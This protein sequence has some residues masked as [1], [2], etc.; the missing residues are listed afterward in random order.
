MWYLAGAYGV[1]WLLVFLFVFVLLGR[2]RRT[3][4]KIE[5]LERLL[6]AVPPADDDSESGRETTMRGR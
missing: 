3:E 1:V 6:E 2:Q 5:A 4:A